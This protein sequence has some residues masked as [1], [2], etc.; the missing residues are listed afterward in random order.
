MS[1]ATTNQLSDF[2]P[3]LAGT[4]E[5]ALI[6]AR[7][8]DEFVI[9]KDIL[10]AHGFAFAEQSAELA[11]LLSKQGKTCLLADTAFHKGSYDIIMQY[12]SGQIQFFDPTNLQ[13]HLITPDYSA[14]TLVVLTLQKNLPKFAAAGFD[15][16]AVAGLTY[17]SPI[18]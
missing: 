7:D 2:F 8:R 5:P 3:H 1:T 4:K 16:R 15:I 18:L 10:T 11:T 12:A 17:Q 9:F 6:I 14:V 13:S